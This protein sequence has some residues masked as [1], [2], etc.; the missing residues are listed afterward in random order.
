MPRTS[1][2]SF[3]MCVVGSSGLVLGCYATVSPQPVAV[4]SADDF[5]YADAP[6]QIETYPVVVYEG[7]PHYYVEGRWYRQ[8][9]RGWAYYRQ[10]PAHLAQRRPPPRAE[11]RREEPRR[12]EPRREERKGEE[13]HE[14]RR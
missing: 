7:T 4:T 8:T 3:V 11:P 6:P 14:E 10:E 5:V 13:R 12:E 2:V 1:F 9:P